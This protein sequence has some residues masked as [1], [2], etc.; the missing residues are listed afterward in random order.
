MISKSIINE[1]DMLFP[2]M[3]K[4]FYTLRTESDITDILN[5]YC[6]AYIKQ[7]ATEHLY[8]CILVFINDKS[9]NSFQVDLLR[10]DI[11]YVQKNLVY[12]TKALF[13][14]Y[15]DENCVEYNIL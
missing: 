14:Q 3:V 1:L 15:L 8:L 6:Y 11:P 10:N 12:R 4:K 5:K 13:N 7:K 9:E 2:D